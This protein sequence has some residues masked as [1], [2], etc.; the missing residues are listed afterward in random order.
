MHTSASLTPTLAALRTFQ[1]VPGPEIH[2][3][4]QAGRIVEIQAGEAL[5]RTGDPAGTGWLVARGR[6]R[7]ETGQPA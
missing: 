5:A 3:L 2:A 1:G 6:I 7:L 4:I